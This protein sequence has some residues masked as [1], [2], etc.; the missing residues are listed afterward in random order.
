MNYSETLKKY[1]V[2]DPRAVKWGTKQ[3]QY[4]RFKI[5]CEIADLTDGTVVD[6]GCGLGDLY[7]YLLTQGFKGKY[8]GV[9]ENTNMIEAA[10]SKYPVKFELGHD[11]PQCDYVIMSGV[12]NEFIPNREKEIKETLARA[13][14]ASVKGVA[15]NGIYNGIKMAASDPAEL[16]RFCT[17]LTPFVTLRQDYREGN[18][19]IY[20]YRDKGV[21]F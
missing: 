2:N 19:T 21:K 20:M 16:F 15:Y 7:D 4:F 6:Y 9:D 13:F 14:N 18:F 12:F 10:R 3:T 11:I 1:G 17:T 5:L 8:I